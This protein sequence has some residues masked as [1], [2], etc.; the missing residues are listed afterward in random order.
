MTVF[1]LGY[2]WFTRHTSDSPN[3]F[4]PFILLWAFVLKFALIALFLFLIYVWLQDYGYDFSDFWNRAFGHDY[5]S[6]TDYFAIIAHYL[7]LQV[8]F[9]IMRVQFVSPTAPPIAR[10]TSV[11]VTQKLSSTLSSRQHNFES[12]IIYFNMLA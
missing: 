1:F 8:H 2:F 12:L 9:F 10:R 4:Q 3:R 6:R 7:F 11:C 5:F